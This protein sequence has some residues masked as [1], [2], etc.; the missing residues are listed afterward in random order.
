MEAKDTVMSKSRATYWDSS[1]L[2]EDRV[3]VPYSKV[4][5]QAEISF[6]IGKT[7]GVAEGLRPALKAIEES[8][9][10]G[11]REVVEFIRGNIYGRVVDKKHIHKLRVEIPLIDWEAFL[12]KRG[13]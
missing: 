11:M 4:K 8:R 2:E 7:A 13:L 12:K 3:L 6:K 1:V 10:A 5:E 9:K